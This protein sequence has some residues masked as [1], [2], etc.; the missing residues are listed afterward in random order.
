VFGP[1]IHKLFSGLGLRN[2]LEFSFP[3]AEPIP[4]SCCPSDKVWELSGKGSSEFLLKMALEYRHSLGITSDGSEGQISTLYE[5]LIDSHDKKVTGS[6]PKSVNIGTRELN[7]LFCSVNYEAHS[8]SSS[9]GR[10]KGRV[11]NSLL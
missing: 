10:R 9:S 1:F 7:R 3:E 5:N 6:S 4:L 11:H 2:R 8:G